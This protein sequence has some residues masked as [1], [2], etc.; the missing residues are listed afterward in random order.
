MKHALNKILLILQLFLLFIT[1]DPCKKWLFVNFTLFILTSQKSTYKHAYI[2]A[3]IKNIKSTFYFSRIHE[4]LKWLGWKFMRNI[5]AN[6]V[7]N[8]AAE[9]YLYWGVAVLSCQT[10][11]LH[12]NPP[13]DVGF[14]SPLEDSQLY[15]WFTFFCYYVKCKY[16]R[17]TD[18]RIIGSLNYLL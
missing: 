2:H 6:I 1:L 12:A 3:H 7:W 11:S 9:R 14:D 4:E 16:G 17:P 18:F 5:K 10:G 15:L 13:R 8:N